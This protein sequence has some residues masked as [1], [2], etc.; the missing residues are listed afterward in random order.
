MTVHYQEYDEYTPEDDDDYIGDDRDGY[1]VSHGGTYIGTY[2]RYERAV[3]ALY[4]AR[5]RSKYWPNI[6]QVNDHGNVTL[7][8]FDS[9][10]L[11]QT[12][13]AYV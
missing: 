11:R 8:V 3:A 12:N 2:A 6:W 4:L 10:N 9:H 5:E 7:C 1:A 13:T